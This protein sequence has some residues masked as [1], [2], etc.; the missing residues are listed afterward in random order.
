[1]WDPLSTLHNLERSTNY[2]AI[3]HLMIT[4]FGPDYERKVYGP[5]GTPGPSEFKTQGYTIGFHGRSGNFLTNIGVYVL[6]EL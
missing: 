6:E 5:F 3:N 4:M 1:M 2:T